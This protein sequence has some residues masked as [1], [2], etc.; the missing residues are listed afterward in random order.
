MHV[1]GVGTLILQPA[2]MHAN[3]AALTARARLLR[4]RVGEPVQAG[5]L[6]VR[7]LGAVR[8]QEVQRGQAGHVIREGGAPAAAQRV[9]L[10]PK[11][12]RLVEA[13]PHVRLRACTQA[14]RL[15]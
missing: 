3:G 6:R 7:A 10:A 11:Q 15:S 12:A 13:R 5:R 14:N 9:K 8:Q 2:T 4:G 1:K